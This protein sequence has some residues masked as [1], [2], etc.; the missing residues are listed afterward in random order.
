MTD[1]LPQPGD[2]GDLTWAWVEEGFY[3]ASDRVGFVGY[4]DRIHEASFQVCNAQS[5]QVGFFRDLASAMSHVAQMHRAG[6]AGEE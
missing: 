4:I 2:H 6:S 1:F 3:V 5:Q